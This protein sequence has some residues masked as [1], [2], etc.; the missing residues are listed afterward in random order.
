M[1]HTKHKEQK[2]EILY[3]QRPHT[4]TSSEQP[5]PRSADIRRPEVEHAYNKRCQKG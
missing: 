1:L 3:T 5:I 4:P 2:P